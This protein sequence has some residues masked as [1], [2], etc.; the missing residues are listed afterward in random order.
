VL[1][2]QS[3]GKVAVIASSQS[4]LVP[5][6]KADVNEP[7]E[8]DTAL[9]SNLG[10][11]DAIFLQSNI[12]LDSTI[13]SELVNYIDSGGKLYSE[14]GYFEFQT[15]DSSIPLWLRIGIKGF[16]DGALNFPVDSVYGVDSEFTRNISLD[17]TMDLNGV[18]DAGPY[19][20]IIPILFAS[21]G[22][23]ISQSI[24]YISEDTSIRVVLG[25]APDP[26]CPGYYSE[27]IADVVCNY[28]NL[29]AADVK[30]APPAIAAENISIVRDSRDNGYSVSCDFATGGEVSVFNSLGINIWSA[31]VQTGQNLV[32]LPATLRNGFYFVSVRSGEN[33]NTTRFSIVN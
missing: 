25:N 19:G 24:A 13:Q 2:A 6:V 31:N 8:I 22:Q 3:R 9:P 23:S 11:Y 20:S 10:E 18:E 29:C 14:V 4:S 16:E 12:T 17:F 26:Y 5:L 21:E 32:E 15:V 28:F 27:F 33:L 30:T 7:V 1:H